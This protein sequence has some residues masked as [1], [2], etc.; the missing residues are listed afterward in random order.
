M[1]RIVKDYLH[2]DAHEDRYW[3]N[4]DQLSQYGK[5]LLP[6]KTTRIYDAI[7]SFFSF[8]YPCVA[9]KSTDKKMSYNK[10]FTEKQTITFKNQATEQLIF[11][12]LKKCLLVK[13]ESLVLKLYLLLNTEFINFISVRA[14]HEISE[15]KIK[16]YFTDIKFARVEAFDLFQFQHLKLLKQKLVGT[17]LAQYKKQMLESHP[18]IKQLN[19][20]IKLLIKVLTTDQ[21]AQ[22]S[23]QDNIKKNLSILRKEL[24][25]LKDRLEIEL[26][27]F[28]DKE[29]NLELLKND[30]FERLYN[31]YKSLIDEVLNSD[32]SLTQELLGELLRPIQ[33]TTKIIYILQ[34]N[35]NI[36]HLVNEMEVIPNPDCKHTEYNIFTEEGNDSK[37]DYIGVSKLCCGYCHHE[38]GINK[39]NHRGTHGV[40]DHAWN[41]QN[42]R[43]QID[44]ELTIIEAPATYQHRRLSFDD[45]EHHINLESIHIDNN[46]KDYKATVLGKAIETDSDG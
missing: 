29:Y 34:T 3:D 45:F 27:N 23:E 6:Y 43:N 18:D 38:L 25:E 1:V 8:I 32:N 4:H 20:Q 13:N 40:L 35:I 37:E 31:L 36:E 16:K 30:K 15:E 22:S 2:R 28:F 44:E 19:V 10:S 41:P 21:S 26:T 12:T 9:I 39:I 24:R 33:D 11:N 17:N 42:I 5:R 46:L 7:A 14:E